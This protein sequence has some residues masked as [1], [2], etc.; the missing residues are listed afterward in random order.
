MSGVKLPA[1]YQLSGSIRKQ[2]RAAND[3]ASRCRNLEQLALNQMQEIKAYRRKVAVLK[4]EIAELK[5]K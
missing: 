2:A 4:K 5:K 1:T 3:L